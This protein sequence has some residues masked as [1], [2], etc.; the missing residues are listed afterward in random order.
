MI[1]NTL[2]Q[3]EWKSLKNI[4]LGRFTLYRPLVHGSINFL[5]S[6]KTK[7]LS[8]ETRWN[9]SLLAWKHYYLSSHCFKS[10]AF[11]LLTRAG[12]YLLVGLVQ[13]PKCFPILFYPVCLSFSVFCQPGKTVFNCFDFHFLVPHV[14][15]GKVWACLFF[16]GFPHWKVCRYPKM[17]DFIPSLPIYNSNF[18]L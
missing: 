9:S 10:V 16:W 5:D 2:Y 8:A 14:A 17:F 1:Y 4:P 13:A 15:S 12:R 6:T 11:E 18:S 7:N 3:R